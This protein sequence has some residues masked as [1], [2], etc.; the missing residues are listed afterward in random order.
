MKYAK[1]LFL[2][3]GVGSSFMSRSQSCDKWAKVSA[4]PQH[5][6][7][8]AK[9]GSLW[10][11]GNEYFALGGQD[12]TR[13]VQIGQAHD[14]ASVATKGE[15]TILIKTDGTLWG[16]GDN[17]I[18]ELDSMAIYQTSVSVPTQLGISKAWSK[19]VVGV[20]YTLGIKSDGSL[21]AWGNNNFGQ[22]GDSASYNG[23]PTSPHYVGFGMVQVGKNK[24]W[25]NVV[26]GNQFTIG[27]ASDG[28]LWTWGLNDVG[29]LGYA[30]AGDVQLT[31][32]QVGTAKDWVTIGCGQNHGFAI[33]TDG[34]LWAWGWNKYGQ[35]GVGTTVSPLGLTQVG[36][37]KDWAFA[38]GG[39]YASFGIKKD[40]SL[41][42]WGTDANFGVNSLT[43]VRFG[44]ENTWQSVS[45][46]DQHV[47]A[48]KSEGSIWTWGSN[49][50]G[51]FD[52]G[53][54]NV[55]IVTTPS[56]TL[57]CPDKVFWV[58]DTNFRKAL[59]AA[60]PT[61]F[62][63]NG[64]LVVSA[65]G[66]ITSLAL[67]GKGIADLDGIQFFANLQTLDI[68]N[69]ALTALP[70][71]PTHLTSVQG[72]QNCFC[73]AP[74]KPSTFPST[75]TWNL[76]PNK[77]SCQPLTKLPL[78]HFY[79]PSGK[80]TTVTLGK[81]LYFDGVD[82]NIKIPSLM[83]AEG[84]FTIEYWAKPLELPT[85]FNFPAIQDIVGQWN[86]LA[87][88]C[89]GTKGKLIIYVNGVP[90]VTGTLP[91]SSL[92]AL[93]SMII[94]SAGNAKYHGYM[95]N[96]RLWDKVL[97]AQE[98]SS[99]LYT[100]DDY[101]NPHLLA[102]LKLNEGHGTVAIDY[103]AKHHNGILQGCAWSDVNAG[104]G[105]NWYETFYEYQYLIY[106]GQ[107]VTLNFTNTNSQAVQN[108]YDVVEQNTAAC[109][110]HQTVLVTIAPASAN[111]REEA[112]D[113]AAPESTIS[114][115]PNPSQDK[116][117]LLVPGLDETVQAKLLDFQGKTIREFELTSN[118]TE[119]NVTGLAAGMYTVTFPMGTTLVKKKLQ[120]LK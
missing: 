8:I 37:A 103:S 1:I 61:C 84:P 32:K 34:S 89:T 43:P 64:Y 105:Y 107:L 14:W 65:L 112:Q 40:G 78:E 27:L 53:A 118:Q 56:M 82:D 52:N 30:T 26:T 80:D 45:V 48:M 7:A 68:T 77:S 22:L 66:P 12:V 120:I 108:I 15:H 24:K 63:S 71:L 41:W 20:E 81:A 113:V 119:L 114:L 33:K 74:S 106:T 38:T 36:T 17:F 10:G 16:F 57:D 29:E 21:W 87:I 86:H 44:T 90:K 88:T 23:P 54:T 70:T 3:L 11:W 99:A 42:T 93:N 116:V 115:Y 100:F 47:V 73:S 92:I 94:G 117:F 79:I 28:T 67:S 9:D 102:G 101:T 46:G 35:L 62:N 85:A 58:P 5:T 96:F 31:P 25:V 13:A 98:I 72:A 95:H 97:T 18:T 104:A 39:Y 49:A 110:V 76:A 111:A 50:Y 75:G 4:G 69:N 59:K 60:C 83:K 2:L 6:F 91:G 51:Q 109:S 55:N 19:V